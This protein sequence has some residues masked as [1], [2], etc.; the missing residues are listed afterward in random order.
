MKKIIIIGGGIGGLT[1][2]IALKQK[3][4]E[5]QVFE[6]AA[7]VTPVGAGILLAS[8]ALNVYHRLG[9]ADGLMKLGHE[10]DAANV[11][12][13]DGKI[14][15]K[16]DT[17]KLKTKYNFKTIAI[18]RADLHHFL[19]QQLNKNEVKIDA[20]FSH[21]EDKNGKVIAYFTNGTQAEG[22]VLIGADG[23]HS[24]V[25]TQ[26][27]GASKLRYSGQTCWRF[28]ADFQMNDKKSIYEYW[29]NE[30]G[31]RVGFSH[32]NDK[33]IYCFITDKTNESGRDDKALLKKHLL[34]RCEAFNPEIKNLIE[35]ADNQSIIRNDI[36]D[37]KPIN[38]YYKGN[39]ILLGDAAHATTPNLGQGA[40]Q[41]IEDAY[42][43]A[44]CLTKNEEISTAF[45]K[46]QAIRMEK[47]K[48]IVNTSWI[49]GKISNT[50]GWFK[51]LIISLIRM[52]PESVN[53]KQMDKI[54][55]L[56]F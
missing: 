48:H 30:A 41:A 39:I 56:N 3:G 2:A 31:L 36:F 29:A 27:F 1:T 53:E 15:S 37:F 9:I 11:V 23:I 5:V 33:Q 22:D 25:R 14:I 52:T 42:V 8:N 4:V 7:E 40:C 54:F 18:H 24:K 55:S 10:V 17:E 35:S 19:Y 28:V 43:I 47:A 21:F 44:E 26:L 45:A 38:Q 46:F 49:F 13:I 16:I 20:Q 34:E 6:Q 51:K 50:S 12:N 32:I